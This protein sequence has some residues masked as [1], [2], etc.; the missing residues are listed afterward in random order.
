[1]VPAGRLRSLGRL[2]RQEL[3]TGVDF[4]RRWIE[5]GLVAWLALEQLAGTELV[6]AQ[7][8]VARATHRVRTHWVAG[9]RTGDRWRLADGRVLSI[10]AVENVLEQ[11]RE[12]AM[13]CVENVDQAVAS[14]S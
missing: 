5:T 10:R 3:D 13:L 7:Q 6:A 12:L 11:N 14:E 8:I 9:V 1:M 4:K 2:E